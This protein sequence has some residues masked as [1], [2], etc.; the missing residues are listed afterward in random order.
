[1]EYF[2]STDGVQLDLANRLF[3][4]QSA[5]I[6]NEFKKLLENCYQAETDAVDFMNNPSGACDIINKWVSEKTRQKITEIVNTECIDEET[7]AVIT[8][9]IY[10]KG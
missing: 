9:A 6:K 4:E 2:R 8:N 7:R 5:D 10:F 3:I 1:M